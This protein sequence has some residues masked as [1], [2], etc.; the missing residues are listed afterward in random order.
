MRHDELW[1]HI[2]QERRA[3][4]GHLA[5]LS[6]GDWEHESLCPGW[7]V[8]DVAAHV[9]SNP[10]V[11]GRKI[12]GMVGRNLGRGYN[13]MIFRE[14]KRWSRDQT[15]ARI[16]EDFD[17]YDGSTRH[18]PLTTSVEPLLDVIVHSQD[19]LRPL[20]IAY[21]ANPEAAAVAA[22]RARLHAS[23]MG[24]GRAKKYRLVA[25]DLDWT[26]GKGPTVEGPVNELLMLSTGRDPDWTLLT[27]AAEASQMKA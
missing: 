22:D 4:A 21:A 7:T 14:T 23:Y 11:G 26:R 25:T 13:T 12:L 3:L 1:H 18:V 15:P 17:R 6:P 8:L 2:H 5:G 24:W 16:L 27:L 19:I 9:I 10:Q 20:G